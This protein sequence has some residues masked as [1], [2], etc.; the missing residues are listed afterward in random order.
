ML[1]RDLSCYTVLQS[2]QHAKIQCGSIGISSCKDLINL[3]Q[4][5]HK[6][7]CNAPLIFIYHKNVLNVTNF[8]F[9]LKISLLVTSK[10]KE[11]LALTK[12]YGF[13]SNRSKQW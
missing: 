3:T 4:S 12:Y 10:L 13:P 8:K 2:E 11:C 9:V 5:F 1:I 7:Y 6:F